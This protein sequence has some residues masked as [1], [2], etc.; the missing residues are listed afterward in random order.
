MPRK[1]D[2]TKDDYIIYDEEDD[3][4]EMYFVTGGVFGIG[5]SLNSNGINNSQYC[6]SR[7]DSAPHLICDHYVVN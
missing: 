3:V 5:F 1:F 6:L 4:P 2:N 7:K